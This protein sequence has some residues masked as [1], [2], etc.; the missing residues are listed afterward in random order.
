MT[1]KQMDKVSSVLQQMV[2]T[3]REVTFAGILRIPFPAGMPAVVDNPPESHR[4]RTA[5]LQSI[6]SRMQAGPVSS[7]L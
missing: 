2:N 3:W 7:S 1:M 5:L 4:D 6:R